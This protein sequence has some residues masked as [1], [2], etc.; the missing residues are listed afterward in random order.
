MTGFPMPSSEA[1]QKFLHRFHEQELIERAQ[2]E[3]GVGQVS[4][5]P[6]ESE[7][8]RALA[9]VHQEVVR[10]LGRRCADQK[11]ATVDLDATIIE[12]RKKRANPTDESGTVYQPVLALSAEMDV[13]LADEFRD[14]NVPTQQ[15]PLRVT[16][17][18]FAALP[19]TVGEYNFRGDAACEEEALL[20]WLRHEQREGGR[21]ASLALR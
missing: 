12:S 5:I 17:R 21:G 8:L 19:E 9:Q 18:A 10:E 13:V 2:R 7:P 4:Y 15:Q 16:Q 14:G 6:K 11:T 20:S 3:F 1:A